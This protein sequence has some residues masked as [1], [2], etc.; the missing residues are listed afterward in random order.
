MTVVILR[1]AS[2]SSS[3]TNVEFPV[4]NKRH[5]A[6]CL[7]FVMFALGCQSEDSIAVYTA[8]RLDQPGV[9]LL[10]ALLPQKEQTWVFKVSGN[11]P[12][13]KAVAP[14]FDQ[15]VRSVRFDDKD[16]PIKWTAPAGWR[17][18]AGNQ[19]RH[20]TLRPGPG[21]DALEVTVSKLQGAQADSIVEN[22]NRWRGQLGLQPV[23]AAGASQL[24]KTIK[25]GD[26]DV[27]L[28]D[29]AGKG[30]VKGMK[31][32]PVATRREPPKTPPEPP[33]RPG[34]VFRKPGDWRE[35]ADP[36]GIS[37]A[38]FTVREGDQSA[39]ITVT[40]L[41]GPAGGLAA[42]INRWRTQINL[43]PLPEDQLMREIREVNIS[44]IRG[45]AVEM[46]GP[47]KAS[48]R[49]RISGI[50]LT[51]GDVTWFFKMRGGADLVA[52]QQPAFEAFASS[53]RLPER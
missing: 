42:N 52:R 35:K 49:E 9:R 7:C 20:A 33:A 25:V 48:G 36:S 6:V 5:S 3:R 32:P 19:F 4:L 21:D 24:C 17:E 28:V 37:A 27:T 1:T 34:L 39:D 45:Y 10:A 14:G 43:P 38:S 40:S 44:G 31:T 29:M 12:A 8:P 50:V 51:Q 18:E 23:N 46:L 26:V 11:E 30:Q 2:P 47:D 22:I 13:V 41:P 16:A 15:L 53:V